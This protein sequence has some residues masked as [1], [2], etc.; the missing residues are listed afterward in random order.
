VYILAFL[1]ST[2]C[3]NDNQKDVLF[4]IGVMQFSE[5]QSLVDAY[6]G[7]IDGLKELGYTDGDNIKIIYRTAVGT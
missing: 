2:G 1:F 3:S 4:T 5:A 7:F 6:D